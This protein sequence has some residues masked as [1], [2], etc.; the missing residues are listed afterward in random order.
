MIESTQPQVEQP[1]NQPEETAS[2]ERTES[3]LT[4]KYNKEETNL[5]REDATTYAQKGM[6][7]DKLS[8]RLEE[9]TAKLNEYES[10]DL[11]KSVQ[12]AQKKGLAQ[13]SRAA[14]NKQLDDFMRNNPD[15]DPRDLS[16]Q[17]LDAW[18]SGV[19]LGE[20]AAAYQAGEYKSEVAVL[21]KQIAQMKTN[22]SNAVASMGR[23][24]SHGPTQQKPLS[25]EV[26]KNMSKKELEKN[27]ERIWEFLTGVKRKK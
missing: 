24:Q 20:A 17:V 5:S 25:N 26:I 22:E 9:V 21:Q 7:Y 4:V 18:R 1:A 16:A 11:Q 8:G 27:H 19:P 2:N 23:P 13:S 6:N 10:S 15:I 12:K 14:V 3:F